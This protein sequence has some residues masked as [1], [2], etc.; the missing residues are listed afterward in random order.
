M[1]RN[2]RGALVCVSLLSV[3]CKR[4]VEHH[5]Q[6][7]RAPA[8]ST[9][10]SPAS[11][12]VEGSNVSSTA[13]SEEPLGGQ[14]GSDVASYPPP[15]VVA[16]FDQATPTNIGNSGITGCAAR[17]V[18]GWAQIRCDASNAEGGALLGAHI[19]SGAPEGA[20]LDVKP[21][22]DGSLT[23][24]LPWLKG[25]RSEV[26]FEWLGMT[27]DLWFSARHSKFTRVL[28]QEQAA[29]CERFAKSSQ[30]ILAGIRGRIGPFSPA[31]LP[32]DVYR[33]PNVGRCQMAGHSAWALSLATLSASGEGP[34]REVVVT[35]ALNH[36]DAEGKVDSQS[37]G[38]LAFAPEGLHLP[39]LMVY[40]YDADGEAE[41][42]IRQELL[43]RA[44]RSMTKV[45]PRMPAVYTY[46][47]GKVQ[48][49]APLS[50]LASGGILAEQLE[51]DGRPDV[52]DYG[53]FLSWLP[54]KCGRGE[55]PKRLTGPR[56]F[57]RSTPDGNFS[58]Q[59]AVTDGVI[60]SKCERTPK[61]LVVDV[62]SVSGKR[63]TAH[64]IACARVR[65]DSTQSI[66]AELDEL[67]AE[68]CEETQPTCPLYLTLVAWASA[69]PPRTRKQPAK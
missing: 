37:Y 63:Q 68:M 35:F 48:P 9:D 18:P 54:D 67:K 5:E 53:P 65:G 51:G 44:E 16:N 4:T 59:D 27:Q 50:A 49:Y 3:G 47:Q 10:V 60:R 33:F 36:V 43:L 19:K 6:A 34:N 39:E 17:V 14:T 58:A 21:S 2:L 22:Q 20:P 30:Q 24:V 64:N 45:L 62:R 1:F 38:P 11:S 41:V 32:R 42:I 40:D 55:C 13:S 52:G 56:F 23:L 66:V 31:V 12:R 25:Q 57:L 8:V 15:L 7:E 69:T 28:P 61:Q 46:K 26:R 29:Q